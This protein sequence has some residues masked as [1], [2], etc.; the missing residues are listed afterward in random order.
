MGPVD[1]LSYV[2]TAVLAVVALVLGLFVLRPILTSATT[3]PALAAPSPTLALPPMAGFGSAV[4]DGEVEPAF[5]IP[6]LTRDGQGALDEAGEDDPA[7]RLRRLI[8]QRQTESIE[9]LRNWM[10][11]EEEPA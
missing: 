7:S 11:H 4:L 6:G 8:A 3:R 5:D 2:Q 9:I 1:V 10:E